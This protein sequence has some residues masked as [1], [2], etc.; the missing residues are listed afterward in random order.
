MTAVKGL[1]IT[2]DLTSLGYVDEEMIWEAV[3]AGRAT[4]T[5]GWLSVYEV[6]QEAAKF[7]QCSPQFQ[8]CY[9]LPD[10]KKLYVEF[11][12]KPEGV[13]CSHDDTFVL[14]RRAEADLKTYGVNLICP[15]PP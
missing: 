10:E 13:I 14:E 1:P 6:I 11:K 3:H 12:F 5:F 15:K 4:F 2:I 8:T 7:A 9:Y